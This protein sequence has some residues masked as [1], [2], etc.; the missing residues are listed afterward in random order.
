M[1]IQNLIVGMLVEWTQRNKPSVLGIVSGA[2][3]GLVA[4]TPAA[5]FVDLPGGFVI[6]IVSGFSCYSGGHIA[7]RQ[8]RL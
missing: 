4:I 3:G 8:V 5:G 2:I 1:R 7:Q 6:G